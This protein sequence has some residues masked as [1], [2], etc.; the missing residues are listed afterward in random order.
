MRCGAFY[1]LIVRSHISDAVKIIRRITRI[2]K[3]NN[4]GI[5]ISALTCDVAN[6]GGL[7]VIAVAGNG[8]FELISVLNFKKANSGGGFGGSRGG[9]CRSGGGGLRRY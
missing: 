2:S 9:P 8:M 4:F 7:G 3:S 1:F 5:S 6:S